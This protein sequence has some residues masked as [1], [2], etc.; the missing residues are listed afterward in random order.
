MTSPR[1]CESLLEEYPSE[2]GLRCE[3]LRNTKKAIK[4]AISAPA[5][6]QPTAAPATA[7]VETPL[8]LDVGVGEPVTLTAAEL[9]V[10]LVVTDIGA[11]V[12]GL[13]ERDVEE[14][15]T[16][17]G[18]APALIVEVEVV[19]RFPFGFAAFVVLV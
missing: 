5:I 16:T 15:L 14:S 7:P 1:L 17:P 2:L 3:R 12:D 10:P 4:K 18:T 19:M 6:R 11:E 9:E 13:A 8:L